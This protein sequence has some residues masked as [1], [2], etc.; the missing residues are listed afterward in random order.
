VRRAG[1]PK[2]GLFVSALFNIDID[3]II[4]EWKMTEERGIWLATQYADDQ[5]I[6]AKS[7]GE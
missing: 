5:I 3:R 6:I 2:G 7:D 1:Q 4:K